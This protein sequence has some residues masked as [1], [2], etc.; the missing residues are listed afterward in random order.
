MHDSSIKSRIAR[1]Q[2]VVALVLAGLI[3]NTADVWVTLQ[4]RAVESNPVVL[5]LG[6][7]GWMLVKAGA[8]VGLAITAWLAL[9][10]R[11]ASTVATG[12]LAV[13]L[14]GLVGN[15]SASGWHL[16]HIGQGALGAA[17]VSLLVVAVGAVGVERLQEVIAAAS[18]LPT[19][20]RRTVATLP[21]S[22][23]DTSGGIGQ[24]SADSST[25][26][27]SLATDSEIQ[28][29]TVFVGDKNGSV[30]A[31]NAD[32]GDKIWSN[33]IS[34]SNAVR[35]PTVVNGSVF[36]TA[37]DNVLYALNASTG[38]ISWSFDPGSE[39]N[40]RGSPTI[41]NNTA[42]YGTEDGNLYAVNATDG[43]QKW[44]YSTDDSF[45]ASP[46]V[47]NGTVF[48]GDHQDTLHA[49]NA[50][51]GST[52]WT[53]TVS[54]TGDYTDTRI[55]KSAAVHN[56]SV[57]F[58][59]MGGQVMSLDSETGD[60]NWE[61]LTK[62]PNDG[63]ASAVTYSNGALYF[64]DDAGYVYSINSSDGGEKWVYNASDV[65]R[66]SPTVVSG[67][68]YVGVRSS[69]SLHALDASDG[70]VVWNN[71][72]GSISSSPTVKSGVIY[73]GSRDTNLYA[74]NSDDGSV[75]WSFQTP[76][77]VDV[78]SSPTFVGSGG[79]KSTGSRVYLAT[80][81]HHDVRKSVLPAGGG[82]FA[83]PLVNGT[84]TDQNGDPVANA[85]VV[86]W[87]VDYSNISAS[88]AQSKEEKA[89]ELIQESKNVR[90]KSYEPDLQLTGSSGELSTT[91]EQYVAVHTAADWA[92]RGV[93]PGGGFTPTLGTDPQ[94]GS[95]L[96][97]A[98]AN[99]ELILTVWDPTK[100]G[101]IQDGADGDLSGSTVPEST[102]LIVEQIGPSNSTIKEPLRLETEPYAK[103]R[104]VANPTVK[105]HYAASTELPTGFYRVSVE[106]SSFSYVMAVGDTRQMV[107]AIQADLNA[108]ADQYS[109]RA[110]EVR[111]K[112]DQGKFTKYR[113]T[114]NENGSFNF[115]TGSNVKT[116][117]IQAHKA[118]PGINDPANA[119]LEDIRTYY[120]TT[121][122]NGS[123]ILPSNVE[124]VDA[125][126][127][128]NTVR[129]REYSA[130]NYPDLQA[131][132]NKTELFN[133][134]LKNL[135]YSEL[136]SQYQQPSVDVT[137]EQWKTS[138]ETLRSLVE[139]RPE[140]EDRAQELLGEDEELFIDASEATTADLRQRATVMQ[141]AFAETPNTVA[142]GD[143]ATSSTTDTISARFPFDTNLEPEDVM[144]T[145]QYPNS[146][147]KVL[148]TSSEYVSV[149]SNIGNDAIVINDFPVSSDGPASVS[150]GVKVANEDGIA[151]DRE[152]VDNPAVSG[153]PPSIEGISLSTLRPGPDESV[154]MT[155][156]GG[157]ETTITNITQATV[158]GP[159][160]S[161][162]DTTVESNQRIEF[163]TAG[164]GVHTMQVTFET[165]DGQTAT[166]TERI[167][168]GTN[169][170]AMPPGVRVSESPLGVYAVTGDG[171]EAGEVAI[172]NGGSSV[173]V[174]AQLNETADIPSTLHVYT[175]GVSL[176]PSSDLTVRVVQGDA[177]QSISKNVVV[178]VHLAQLPTDTATI[179]A[180]GEPL[181]RDGGNANGEVSTSASGTTVQ[182]LTD[183]NGVLELSTD[184]SP[185][186]IDRLIY[187][188]ELDTGFNIPA[189]TLLPGLPGWA[190]PAGAGLLV[191]GVPLA[192][193]RSSR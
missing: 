49:V 63:P 164:K 57:F 173:T 181:P 170:K 155:I 92:L 171:I 139:G 90:P 112:V 64:A 110:Q 185:G 98:P 148:N 177:Q 68:V 193:R 9:D 48:I 152:R 59:T 73:V 80:L 126:S 162:L 172:E 163:T 32:T 54:A 136:P 141:Q 123:V 81:G 91:G 178:S 131:F 95:P 161:K 65:V 182:T 133:Q 66:S 174:L 169:P 128:N 18:R 108:T 39:F 188:L 37:G 127:S 7:E 144:V 19:P 88:G 34:P 157:D 122:Y 2:L 134:F 26:L 116:V 53:H 21:A 96:V 86:G 42:Y 150:F 82:S 50:E 166:V 99:E 60:K 168:A 93:D 109:N 76:E 165:S 15:A 61:Y 124:T 154:S 27:Q 87:G 46:T 184:A 191:I 192:A 142:A 94:L 180:N 175:S 51:T 105:T 62:A 179:Y 130:P 129:V 113:T 114:T 11:H 78:D 84:V 159:D 115:S 3:T 143:T 118:P 36:V 72:I 106:N 12:P 145:V 30:H 117:A 38:D 20:S 101:L 75:K 97:R 43:S 83:D 28:E 102:T 85:T 31:V 58:A 47:V 74:V 70:S 125:P 56:G 103:I 151:T 137:R 14:F 1:H 190:P 71:S 135:S 119:S 24:A 16:T 121:D 55:R 45:R 146:T 41:V 153:T 111:E 187:R 89:R 29:A 5:A 158:Y 186:R 17:G 167:T 52:V 120:A 189:L 67:T 13:G 176:P 35:S 132:E 156:N 23:S 4:A 79:S 8:L 33:K 69:K 138:Y 10:H 183:A 160:G 25:N 149:E 40:A 77:G 44:V 6:W 107:Q 140:V 147:S 104:S 100:T 22:F